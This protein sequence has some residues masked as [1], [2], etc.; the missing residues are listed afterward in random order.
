MSN[1]RSLSV[2]PDKVFRSLDGTSVKLAQTTKREDFATVESARYEV[3]GESILCLSSQ[4]GCAMKCGFCRSTE[5]FEFVPGKPKRILRSLTA[6]EIVDQAINA[7]QVSPI[8]PQSKGI[9]FSYMGMGEP[10]ANINAIKKSIIFLGK[11]Y[12]NSRATISTIAFNP[13]GI[14]ELADEIVDGVYSIPVKL[15]ISLHASSDELRKRIIPYALPIAETLSI[16]ESFALKTGTD[17]KLN[18][19]L[20]SG[21]ND[22]EKDVSRLS[23]L[24]KGKR[25]LII[26]LSDLNSENKTLIVSSDKADQFERQLNDLGVRTCRFTSMGRDIHAGCG[27]LVKGRTSL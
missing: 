21:F 25:G 24:L 23:E 9:T 20:V 4:I 2:L 16:A 3:D 22:G 11:L 26:K 7:I 15:H 10:F 13:G 18:Y 12:P 19:V 1:E 5:P 17:V 27:E 6:R 8:P 14:M